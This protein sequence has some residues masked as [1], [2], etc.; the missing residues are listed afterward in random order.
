MVKKYK[1]YCESCDY[2]CSRK[3]LMQQHEKNT[4][5]QS[6]YFSAMLQNAHS[7]IC[8][9]ICKCGKNTNMYKV[10][11]DTKKLVK[12]LSKNLKTQ[13]NGCSRN[14]QNEEIDLKTMITAL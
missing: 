3:F 14:K 13:R 12:L 11:I 4:E 9:H 8:Y 1:Y 2:G 7:K 6:T 5:T 10:L